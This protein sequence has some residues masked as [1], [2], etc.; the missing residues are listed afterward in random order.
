MKDN[1]TTQLFEIEINL[2]DDNFLNRL[3]KEL[4]KLAGKGFEKI[5]ITANGSIIESINSEGIDKNSFTKITNLQEL[6][7]WVVF[8]LFKNQGALLK[9]EFS[10]KYYET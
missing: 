1:L 3:T 5:I 2:K 7:G 4:Q 6:P 10:V 8:D 9:D